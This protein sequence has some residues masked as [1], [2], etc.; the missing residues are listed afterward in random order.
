MRII[1]DRGYVLRHGSE[2]TPHQIYLQRRQLL[3]RLAAGAAGTA[4]VA[5][6]GRDA[7]AQAAS[8]GKLRALPAAAAR[9]M[10]R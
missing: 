6:A 10:A 8:P 3:Q 1:K 4:F 7:L 2:V 5:W 9:S